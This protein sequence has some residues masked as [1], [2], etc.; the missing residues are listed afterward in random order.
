MSAFLSGL[1][2][3]KNIEQSKSPS[4][5]SN[6][7]F[8]ETLCLTSNDAQT[9]WTCARR[10]KGVDL[11]SL[12]IFDIFE[13]CY[14]NYPHFPE[15]MGAKSFPCCFPPFTVLEVTPS[16]KRIVPS[17]FFL[18]LVSDVNLR[19]GSM[20]EQKSWTFHCPHDLMIRGRSPPSTKNH[21]VRRWMDR[22]QIY[23]E[24]AS[25]VLRL[26]PTKVNW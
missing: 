1:Q 15:S 17:I 26:L 18:V 12:N 5:R 23:R 20:G 7:D 16:S 21:R 19:W 10:R 6:C 24:I 4:C 9:M 2:Q 22:F 11:W 13:A 14:S 3:Q 25:P 8:L